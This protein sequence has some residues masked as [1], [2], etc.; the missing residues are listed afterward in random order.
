MLFFGLFCNKKNNFLH[1]L[2]TKD[3]FVIGTIAYYSFIYYNNFEIAMNTC[4]I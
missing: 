1:K 4:D 3:I 2:M